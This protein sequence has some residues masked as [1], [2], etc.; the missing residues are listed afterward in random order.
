MRCSCIRGH[1]RG[2]FLRS[3]RL[4]MSPVGLGLMLRRP[5]VSPAGRFMCPGV[6]PSWGHAEAARSPPSEMCSRSES[7]SC[8]LFGTWENWSFVKR[9]KTMA[10]CANN[11]SWRLSPNGRVCRQLSGKARANI[12][13]FQEKSQLNE[14]TEY[15]ISWCTWIGSLI[16][17]ITKNICRMW[18]QKNKRNAQG[19]CF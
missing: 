3:R 8:L 19:Q 5:S 1:Q 7:W 13:D 9:R 15:Q 18:K 14:K 17:P 16:T 2:L 11:R 6:H 10:A 4:K 12:W